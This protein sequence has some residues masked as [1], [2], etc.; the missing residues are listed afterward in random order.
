MVQNPWSKY[1]ILLKNYLKI[2]IS[3]LWPIPTRLP[4]RPLSISSKYQNLHL[5]SE[6]FK[7]KKKRGGE[8]GMTFPGGENGISRYELC[9]V[10]R[11]INLLQFSVFKY[12]SP[13]GRI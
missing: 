6:R 1:G 11:K 8:N 10:N 5:K 4:G 13:A 7:I 2:P 12:I 3:P 9:Q